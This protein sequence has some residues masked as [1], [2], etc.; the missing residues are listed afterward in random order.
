MTASK[1]S[2]N[3]VWLALFVLVV[4]W[5][6]NFTV[7]KVAT[8]YSGPF[9]FSA[10]RYVIGTLVLF[11]LLALR[12]RDLKSPPWVL[13]IL[14]GLFQTT[15][16][17]ALMQWAL[18]TGGAGKVALF[19]YTMPF[20][21]VPLA[22]WW[23]NEKPGLVHWGCIALAALGLVFVIAPWDGVGKP[24]S[25]VLA[26]GGGLA[27]AISVVLSKHV[28]QRHPSV[29]VLQLTAWQMLFGTIVL[30][31]LAFVIPERSVVWAPEYL[32]ALLYNGLISSGVCWLAWALIVQR[33]PTRVSGLMA[34]AVPVAAVLFAWGLLGERPSGAETAGIVLIAIALLSLN[35]SR[36]IMNKR[37]AK[38]P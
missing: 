36:Q 32:F 14:I 35:F 2:Q 9:T 11:A 15:G 30:V 16:F 5:G 31:A 19:I 21:V 37:R 3:I 28:F 25:I 38:P 17:Q 23:L 12:R 8:N 27:W 33:L 22:W 6:F 7:M 18:M 4:V 1:S 13:T 26:I 29:T 20:W 10:Q 24:E 34:L